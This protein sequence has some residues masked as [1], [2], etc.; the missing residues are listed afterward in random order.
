MENKVF[1]KDMFRS[2]KSKQTEI[3]H[4]K[5]QQMYEVN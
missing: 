5:L 3:C 2:L 4:Y 1:M